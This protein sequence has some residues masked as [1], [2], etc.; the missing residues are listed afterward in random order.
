MTDVQSDLI[1]NDRKAPPSALVIFGASGD[2]TR[3]KL[4]PGLANL[5]RHKR[6]PEE[7]AVVGVG[8][9]DFDDE[10]FRDDTEALVARLVAYS[11]TALWGLKSN[12]LAAERTSFADYVDLESERHMRITACEDT[13]EG[14]RAFV[15]KRPPRFTGN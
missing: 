9:S 2:L 13:A 8:R 15:E 7:F 11:P 1:V 10:T 4:V 12:L 5:A 3:R 14:F 6:L